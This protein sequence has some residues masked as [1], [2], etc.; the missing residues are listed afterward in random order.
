MR[1]NG[2]LIQDYLLR[3]KF[4]IKN[5]DV[6]IFYWPPLNKHSARWVIVCGDAYASFAFAQR[7]YPSQ[8]E[9]GIEFKQVSAYEPITFASIPVPMRHALAGWLWCKTGGHP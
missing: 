7:R 8:R 5:G 4:G 2:V 3:L 6:A 9:E 1:K